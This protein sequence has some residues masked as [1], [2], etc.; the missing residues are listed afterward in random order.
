MF[1][2]MRFLPP[3]EMTAI[4]K[5]RVISNGCEKSR[6]AARG[7]FSL[8]SKWQQSMAAASF[9]TNVS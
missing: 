2:A 3:V 7:D 4:D 8:R 1:C 6:S 5:N 9:R